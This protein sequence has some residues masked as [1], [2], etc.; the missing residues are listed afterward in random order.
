MPEQSQTI[1]DAQ[2]TVKNIPGPVTGAYK[3]NVQMV[4]ERLNQLRSTEIVSYL[5]YKQHAYMIVSLVGPGIKGEFLEHAAQELG[6]ADMLGERIS[7]LGGTPLYD[8]CEISERAAQQK[9]KAE[10]GVTVEEMVMED[11]EVERIQVERY[12]N[13][14][15][16]IG[17]GDIVTR[18]LLIG[19]LKDTEH[20]AAELRD[21][22]QHRA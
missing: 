11:L 14:I 1:A 18:E 13:L 3:A 17:D 6:H 21:M 8:L 2:A 12:T 9:V 22:L 16:E 15:R 20:H 19:I 7:Q 5:Q 10:Q 4:I